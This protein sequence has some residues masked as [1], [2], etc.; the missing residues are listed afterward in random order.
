MR[1]AEREPIEA[2]VAKYTGQGP[3]YT[4]YPTAVELSPSVTDA[5]WERFL[6]E[7]F[8]GTN[9]RRLSLYFHIPFCKSLCYF[10]ACHKVIPQ[11][12]DVVAPYLD[13]MKREI[14]LSRSILGGEARV[15]Q[16]HWGGGSPNFLNSKEASSLLSEV[17]AAF[18]LDFE[19]GD[20]SLEVDPRTTELEMIS[21][22]RSLGF[23]RISF[24]VQDLDPRVQLAIHRTQSSDV[25]ERLVE[26]SRAEGFKSINFDLIYG[27]PE[28]TAQSFS[29]TI[30]RVIELRPDRLALYG[31]AH[32]TWIRKTQ[33]TF[34][35]ANLPDPGMRLELFLSAREAL[36]QAGYRHIGLDH[37]AL[38]DDSLSVAA[39]NG[40]LHRNFMGYTSKKRERLLAFGASAISQFP[41]MMV[42]NHRE[43]QAYR[44]RICA[45]RL[46]IE[47]GLFRTP[48]DRR[49]GMI[50]D[51][52]LCRGMIDVSEWER[53]WQDDF[54]AAFRDAQDS[55]SHFESDG[56][57]ERSGNRIVLTETG[58]LFSRNVAMAFDAH[59]PARLRQT[60]KVFSSTV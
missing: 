59:L 32:V 30:R 16:L 35:K 52:I 17:S 2:L 37:F 12:R 28:Q 29:E 18:S 40:D 58:R 47:R 3:R 57:V 26:R 24:G 27:L 34:E 44:E 53:L 31:Y 11:N 8:S 5:E 9:D 6:T 1:A 19:N 45:G 49:R 41:G 7:D 13:A 22:Y 20:I 33:K 4:S 50:I 54:Q 14:E 36:L 60:A 25:V 39:L 43:L 55:L 56:I 48:D 23:N 10:C 46:P 51:S 15:D 38:P 21:C 42:Q